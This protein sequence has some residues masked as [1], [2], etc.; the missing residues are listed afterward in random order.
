[1]KL[2][3]LLLIFIL[4]VLPLTALAQE[5]TDL[6]EEEI[7]LLDRMLAGF[8]YRD[9][10]SSYAFTE[11]NEVS[12]SLAISSEG[13]TGNFDQFYLLERDGYLIRDETDG[14][15]EYFA[16]GLSGE[17]TDR[18]EYDLSA[19]AYFVDKVLYLETPD[20]LFVIE[21]PDALPDEFTNASLGGLFDE[22]P[23][24]LQNRE[25]M[26]S[27][28][29]SVIEEEVELDGETISALTFTVAEDRVADFIWEFFNTDTNAGNPTVLALR[30]FGEGMVT[31]ETWLD[32]NDHLR[33]IFFNW[34]IKATD[35][36]LGEVSEQ[37]QGNTLDT[38]SISQS[39]RVELG[40]YEEGFEPVEAPSEPL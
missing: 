21:D 34:E 27:V 18:G 31:I 13:D 25:L 12:L 37:F 7:E 15:D 1:L 3:R 22:E 20:E 9:E 17:D 8:E 39:A 14:F 4:L 26:L 36:D 16:L 23:S 24:L 2:P 6:S 38:I 10:V 28:L 5:D 29:E 30:D 40:D 19:D 35:V 32:E 11:V 33:Q